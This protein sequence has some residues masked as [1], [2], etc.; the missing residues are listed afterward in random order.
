MPK[1]SRHSY[2]IAVVAV[3]R[4]HTTGISVLNIYRPW[5]YLNSQADPQDQKTNIGYE[6]VSLC[7][8][9]KIRGYAHENV[10]SKYCFARI[11]SNRQ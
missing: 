3:R 11:L 1:I 9:E 5:S 6:S 8:P 7:L 2:D 10:Q 4:D